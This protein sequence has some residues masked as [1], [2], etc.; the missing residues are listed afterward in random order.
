MHVCAP[1][2][3]TDSELSWGGDLGS[4]VSSLGGSDALKSKRP[5]AQT[6]KP[7]LESGVALSVSFN[8]LGSQALS[9]SVKQG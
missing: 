9:S 7:T 3:C 6:Q 5:L 1:P 8:L 2:I 4:L